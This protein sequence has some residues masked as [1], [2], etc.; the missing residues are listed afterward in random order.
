MARRRS[1]AAAWASIGL[2]AACV[3]ALVAATGGVAHAQPTARSTVAIVSA[4]DDVFGLRVRAELEALGFDARITPP[5]P[6]PPSRESLEAA[7]R[8]VGGIAAIRGVATA[9]GVEVWIADRVTGKTVLRRMATQALPAAGDAASRD[10]AL[11][12]RVVELLRASFLETLMPNA[13]R[14]EVPATPDLGEKLRL[15]QAIAEPAPPA[16][17]PSP[18]AR[19]PATPLPPSSPEVRPPTPPLAAAPPAPLAAPATVRLSLAG[20]ALASPGGFGP[21]FALDIGLAWMPS[22][23]IGGMIFAAFTP[24]PPEVTRAGNTASLTAVLAGG[25]ARFCFTAPTSRW[26]PWADVGVTAIVVTSRATATA[27]GFTQASSTA[28]TP[29]PFARLGLA[30]ALSPVVRLRADVLAGVVAQGVTVQFGS[31]GSATWG[32]PLVAPTLG[33]DFGWF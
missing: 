26:L 6:G 12:L 16:A 27:Q 30:F 29:A 33:V 9:D 1:D 10:A 7:A 5:D 23:H 13:P 11:A 8:A 21:S 17:E 4:A 31:A 15:R 22:D 19:L 3:H 28:A 24:S 14:G 32:R 18:T 20:G 2:G 25:G